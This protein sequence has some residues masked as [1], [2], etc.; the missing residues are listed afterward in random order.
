MNKNCGVACIEYILKEN[1][2]FKNIEPSLIWVFDLAKELKSTGE[3]EIEINYNSSKLM[4]DY[5][6][7]TIV[8][9]KLKSLIKK[10]ITVHKI[11]IVENELTQTNYLDETK[12]ND[13][14]IYCVK[15]SIL[16]NNKKMNGSHY[17]VYDKEKNI[18]LNPQKNKLTREK[19]SHNQVHT[20]LEGN[21][22]WR[23]LVRR[24]KW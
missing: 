3:F 20:M 16:N 12:N 1:E 18:F 5:Q 4:K 2:I 7:N 14:I 6:A 23:I 8:E 17:I 13:Y 15:S 9:E 11:N 22:E 21:G 19:F 10:T 24:I